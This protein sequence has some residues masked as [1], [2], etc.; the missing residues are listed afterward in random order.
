MN[1]VYTF[2][3]L[4]LTVGPI[5]GLPAPENTELQVMD[6]NS[7]TDAHEIER[8]A[9]NPSK[10]QIYDNDVCVAMIMDFALHR[11]V[12]SYAVHYGVHFRCEFRWFEQPSHY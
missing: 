3:I 1:P 5:L 8:R 2:V 12:S 4:S 6:D 10:S 11:F 9:V 7:K